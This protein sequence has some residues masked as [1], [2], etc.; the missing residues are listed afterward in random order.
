MRLLDSL[1]VGAL[2]VG[3]IGIE[4][5]SAW[6]LVVSIKD[7]DLVSSLIWAAVFV[8]ISI[9]NAWAFWELILR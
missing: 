8:A 1:F 4:A 7:G 5:V 2:L 9:L 3:M 6:F